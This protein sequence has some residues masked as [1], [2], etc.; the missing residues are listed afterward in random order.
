MQTLHIPLSS[1]H[2][3]VHENRSLENSF[4][5][6][7]LYDYLEEKEQKIKEL[8]KEKVLVG[9]ESGSTSGFLCS[10]SIC[11]FN[12]LLKQNRLFCK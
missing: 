8:C 1:K 5:I 4:E 7:K 3:E 9:K 10:Q 12:Q 11:E 2:I 6:Q